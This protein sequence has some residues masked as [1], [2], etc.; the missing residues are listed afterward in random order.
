MTNGRPVSV[1]FAM[2][3]MPDVSVQ[4]HTTLAESFS[5][6]H[7]A[8]DVVECHGVLDGDHAVHVIIGFFG[9]KQDLVDSAAGTAILADIGC[10][11]LSRQF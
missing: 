4:C 6:A 10:H 3:V 8:A 5:S 7:G 9:K 11:Q 2:H 1:D